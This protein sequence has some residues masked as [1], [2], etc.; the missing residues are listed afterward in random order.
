[1][2]AQNRDSAPVV[3][4]RGEKWVC[5]HDPWGND[6]DTSMYCPEAVRQVPPW[7][8]PTPEQSGDSEGAS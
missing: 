4:E 3:V 5:P 7:T 8:P 1:M 6:F 2:T